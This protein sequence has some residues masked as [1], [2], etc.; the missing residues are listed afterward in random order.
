[1]SGNDREVLT[2]PEV[3]IISP[4]TA[5]RS[6][7]VQ[8]MSRRGRASELCELAPPRIR[9]AQWSSAA[10]MVGKL[11]R[12]RDGVTRRNAAGVAHA[13]K[14]R[15]LYPGV[16]EGRT[17]LSLRANRFERPRS[18]DCDIFHECVFPLL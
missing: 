7:R 17:S 14:A 6:Q 9:T 8:T 5:P 10:S 18:R 1:M 4:R 12:S 2:A 16:G 3:G 13:R 11:P 15:L